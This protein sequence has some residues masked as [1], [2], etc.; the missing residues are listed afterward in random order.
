MLSNISLWN[1]FW[2]S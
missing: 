2:R 1:L